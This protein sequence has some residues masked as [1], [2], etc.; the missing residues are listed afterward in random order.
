M[1]KSSGVFF[2]A[3]SLAF[4]EMPNK[5]C[6]RQVGFCGFFKH[7]PRFEFFLLSNIFHARPLAGNANRW[8]F[9]E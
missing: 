1:N 7:F 5:A 3:M 6:T 9:V 4:R 2:Q 8:A